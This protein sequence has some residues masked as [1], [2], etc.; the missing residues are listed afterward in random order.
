MIFS[1][2][3]PRAS[4]GDK[5]TVSIMQGDVEHVVLDVTSKVVDFITLCADGNQPDLAC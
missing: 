3:M 5:Y 4:H 2:G 1:G